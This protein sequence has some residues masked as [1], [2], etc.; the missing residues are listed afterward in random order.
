M[1][2]RVAW[3]AELGAV[4]HA[5]VALLRLRTTT[6]AQAARDIGAG[7]RHVSLRL[8]VS[9]ERSAGERDGRTGEYRADEVR[10][11][12]GRGLRHPPRHVAHRSTDHV[13]SEI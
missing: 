4:A 6:A 7:D 2:V 12:Q 5:L 11:R 3:I 1:V 8:D 9:V 13:H 10:V